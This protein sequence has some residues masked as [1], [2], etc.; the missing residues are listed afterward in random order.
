LRLAGQEY[1]L[2]RVVGHERSAMKLFYSPGTC[3]LAPHIVLREA[4]ATFQ[5]ERVDIRAHKT[6][7]GVDYYQINPKGSVPVLEIDDGE[8]FTEG[9]IICQYIADK[10]GALE[11]MPAAGTIARYRVMEWQNY[12]TSELHKTYSPLFNPA[13]DTAT[14]TLFRTALRKKY[15]WVAGK[16]AGNQ[17]LTGNAFTAADAYL[18]AVTRW[19]KGVEVDLTGLDALSAF[20]DR[21]NQRPAVRAA[22]EVETAKKA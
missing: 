8:R 1:T 7:H 20:M 19:A 15:E 2:G 3:A 21:T 12:I 13:F 9:P 22:I 16:L 10:M 11:L 6:E 18:F 4:K 14:K 17:N 5:L